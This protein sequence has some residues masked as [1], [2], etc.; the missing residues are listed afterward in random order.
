MD[1]ASLRWF[2]QVAD[3]VTVTEVSDLDQVSQSGVSRA[4]ARLEREVGAQL[5]RRS[6]RT[7]R[8]TRAGATFK[9]YVDKL[10]HDLDDG[11]AALSELASPESGTVAIA[12][13][14]SLGTWLVPELVASFRREHPGVHFVLHQVI[15]ELIGPTLWRGEADVEITTLASNVDTVRWRPLMAEPLQLAVPAGH[16]LADRA[17]VRL[18]DVAEDPFVMLNRNFVLRRTSERLC[19]NAGFAPTIAFEGDDLSTVTGFVAARLGVAIV[20]MPR[21]RVPADGSV[22][23]LS[24]EDDGA[25]REIGIA[26]STE[27]RLLPAAAA[28]RRHVVD[29]LS[30][31]GS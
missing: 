22:R 17:S 2:Q 26:W 30:R 11:L 28:F 27:R 31:R 8:M 10:L 1:I 9:R 15:D 3:G 18:A 24:V 13:Q 6:G 25:V 12:F 16:P 23:Y 29:Q 20:P 19:E 4:L 5:L 21:N 7:L 14:P